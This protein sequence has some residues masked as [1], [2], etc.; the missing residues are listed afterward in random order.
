V[1]GPTHLTLA[2][3]ARRMGEAIWLEERLFEALGAAAASDLP[4]DVRAVLS[5]VSRRHAWR[6]EQV[7]GRL[8]EVPGF[9]AAD[10]VAP[11]TEASGDVEAVAAAPTAA[12]S[13]A[14][15]VARPMARLESSYVDHIERCSAISDASVERTLTLVLADLRA[16][17]AALR[18]VG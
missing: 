2:E 1:S 6:A 18:S 5:E 4:A 16:D 14:V 7:R 15:A 11:T 13:V 10:V 8:P 12:E 9:A 17:L 3:T